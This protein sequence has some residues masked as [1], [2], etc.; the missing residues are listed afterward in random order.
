[1]VGIIN[2][3]GIFKIDNIE[4][5]VPVIVGDVAH[6]FI[7]VLDPKGFQ[8]FIEMALFFLAQ[9]LDDF[10]GIGGDEQ[11]G[12]F[13]GIEDPGDEIAMD[14]FEVF[15]DLEFIEESF[16]GLGALESLQNAA[17]IAD[18]DP[19]AFGVFDLFHGVCILLLET[20][21][22]TKKWASGIKSAYFY[23]PGAELA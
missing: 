8:A 18:L 2:D 20:V 3:V 13:I 16:S 14:R 21:L 9:T 7:V 23:S 10:T 15:K 22:Q 17:I 4:L 5:A 11:K 12:V 1:V 6:G 19:S